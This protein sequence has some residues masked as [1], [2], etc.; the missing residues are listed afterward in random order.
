MH[1]FVQQNSILTSYSA[2]SAIAANA[3]LRS[4]AGAGFPLFATYMVRSQPSPFF[5][6]LSH[7]LTR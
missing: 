5:V 3:I 4:I 2:A 1:S 6:G 7:A